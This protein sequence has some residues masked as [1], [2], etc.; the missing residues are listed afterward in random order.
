MKIINSIDLKKYKVADGDYTVKAT[1]ADR[2]FL[3]KNKDYVEV[4]LDEELLNKHVKILLE[5]QILFDGVLENTSLF[6][7]V[8]YIID[9]DKL[10]DNIIIT[11]DS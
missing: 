4:I 5:N 2:F 1:Y 3:F 6:I 7:N 8:N 11:I 10:A 9:L